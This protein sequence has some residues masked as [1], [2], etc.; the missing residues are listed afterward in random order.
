MSENRNRPDMNLPEF[1][2]K[3]I[4]EMQELAQKRVEKLT[5]QN[6]EDCQDERTERD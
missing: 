4:R 2:M 1:V 3:R 5:D 6:K